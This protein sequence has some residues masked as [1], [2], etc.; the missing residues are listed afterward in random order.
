MGGKVGG[1]GTGRVREKLRDKL[2]AVV[3]LCTRVLLGSRGPATSTTGD[4][5]LGARYLS[6][7]GPLNEPDI[8]YTLILHIISH[9]RRSKTTQIFFKK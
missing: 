9:I 1:G 6:Q 3:T 7:L 2:S 4:V 8:K 5:H